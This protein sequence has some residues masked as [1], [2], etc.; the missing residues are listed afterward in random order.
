MHSI[1]SRIRRLI[2]I[3]L[4]MVLVKSRLIVLAANL[5]AAIAEIR[6]TDGG[7]DQLIGNFSDL[8]TDNIYHHLYHI[9]IAQDGVHSSASTSYSDSGLL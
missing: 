4:L 3:E 8:H 6:Q 7:S 5:L 1:S 9:Y 2:R